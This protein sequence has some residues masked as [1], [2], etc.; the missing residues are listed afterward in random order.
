[1][2]KPEALTMMFLFNFWVE[3]GPQTIIYNPHMRA[4]EATEG[5]I[6]IVTPTRK[7]Y[8]YDEI[9]SVDKAWIEQLARGWAHRQGDTKRE[10]AFDLCGQGSIDEKTKQKPSQ[11]TTFRAQEW[12]L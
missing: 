2:A 1:M 8:G 3:T 6:L 10:G 4:N 7:D 11:A 12:R 9:G 5:F